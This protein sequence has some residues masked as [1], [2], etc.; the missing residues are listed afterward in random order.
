M[1]A[2][3]EQWRPQTPYPSSVSRATLVRHDPRQEPGAVVPHAGI[4]AGAL[5]NWRPYRIQGKGAA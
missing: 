4:W 3:A 5:G 1:D 2:L